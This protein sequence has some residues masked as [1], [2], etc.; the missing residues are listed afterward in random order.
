MGKHNRSILLSL[1]NLLLL[2]IFI[3]VR[4]KVTTYKAVIF[5]PNIADGADKYLTIICPAR[6]LYQVK[7]PV[8]DL[9]V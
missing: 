8:M 5:S 2:L 4:T 9:T 1:G 3:A 7:H 6:I